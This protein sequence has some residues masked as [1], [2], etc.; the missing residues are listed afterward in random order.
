MNDIYLS[1]VRYPKVFSILVK[2]ACKRTFRHLFLFYECKGVSVPFPFSSFWNKT[3][4]VFT[5]FSD[6]AEFHS[7]QGVDVKIG[8]KFR[9]P[10]KVHTVEIDFLMHKVLFAYILLFVN[11]SGVQQ[12]EF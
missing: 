4:F 2:L 7:L 5:I 6:H 11:K 10:K 9:L 8:E 1:F 12:I 3:Y